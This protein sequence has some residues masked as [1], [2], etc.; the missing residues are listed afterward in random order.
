MTVTGLCLVVAVHPRDEIFDCVKRVRSDFQIMPKSPKISVNDNLVGYFGFNDSSSSVIKLSVSR[1]NI[2][3][4]MLNI[5]FRNLLLLDESFNGLEKIDDIGNETFP[6]LR[7]F[8][9]SFNALSN[10]RSYVFSHLKEVEI[11]D[12][13]HNC[14]VKFQY[15]QVFLKHEHLKKLYLNDNLLHSIQSTFGEPKS[16][17]LDFLDFSNNF[18]NEFHNYDIQIHHLNMRNNSLKSV[19]IYDAQDMILNAQ[20]NQLVHFFAPRG[21]FIKLNLSH[22][23]FEYLSY[24]ELEEATF[25][26]LSHNHLRQWSPDTSIENFYAFTSSEDMSD[27]PFDKE[28]TRLEIQQRVGVRVEFLNLGYNLIHSVFE[29]RHYKNCLTFN[30]ESNDFED[31]FP[32]QFKSFFPL[33]RRVN[34]FN[35]PLSKEDKKRL[36]LFKNVTTGQPQL[37][38]VYMKPVRT[39]LAPNLL[40]P[41][42]LILLPTLSPHIFNPTSTTLK[43]VDSTTQSTLVVSSPLTRLQSTTQM[44]SMELTTEKHPTE[45]ATAKPVVDK[46]IPIWIYAVM[47]AAIIV[48]T[49]VYFTYQSHGLGANVPYRGF[50]DV[51]NNL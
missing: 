5:S 10:V 29:L 9:L 6:S 28:A 16:M 19:V 25:L 27:T 8:N 42:P 37:N 35:N 49:I 31:V 46:S 33:L 39:A 2:Q 24:V 11:L 18:I 32:Q 38:F 13:S 43:P 44:K 20:H 41:L 40:P 4:P 17:T 12:L 26:D 14:F 47:L 48:S 21:T 45:H 23:N 3:L 22:N 15:D 50:Q 1:T 36:D 34:L 7:L 30:L 51:E